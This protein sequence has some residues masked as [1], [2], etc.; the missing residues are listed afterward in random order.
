MRHAKITMRCLLTS[1]L[2]IFCTLPVWAADK[3]IG[4]VV[5]PH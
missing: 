5:A 2:L 3:G 1:L 4:V